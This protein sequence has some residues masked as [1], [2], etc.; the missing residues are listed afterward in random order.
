MTAVCSYRYASHPDP[1]VCITRLTPHLPPVSCTLQSSGFFCDPRR[2]QRNNCRYFE[3]T[4]LIRKDGNSFLA[5]ESSIF[6]LSEN[7]AHEYN[8]TIE[9]EL[10]AKCLGCVHKRECHSTL[11]CPHG[12]LKCPP[13]TSEC[14]VCLKTIPEPDYCRDQKA[15]ISK[16]LRKMKGSLAH[17]ETLIRDSNNRS[18]Q[19]CRLV[20]PLSSD[21]LATNEIKKTSAASK[22]DSLTNFLRGNLSNK[23]GFSKK[24]ES[25]IKDEK[26]VLLRNGGLRRTLTYL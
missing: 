17:I 4:F 8:V 5:I 21:P 13:S 2:G 20:A 25:L 10:T 11:S 14:S 22:S 19:S 16:H 18:C 1:R 3:Q 26:E 7:I 9:R 12:D 6:R 23:L 24:V 15:N